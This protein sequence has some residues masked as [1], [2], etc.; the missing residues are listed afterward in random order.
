[1]KWAVYYHAVNSDEI[2][3]FNIFEHCGFREK[4]RDAVKKY[5]DKESF[6]DELKSCLVYHFWSK[7]EW[8]V[9][10]SAWCGGSAEIKIDVYDQ[11]MSNW[12][13]FVDYCWE[14]RKDMKG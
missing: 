3:T 4:F 6:A 1:M 10:V 5:K 8:E 14:H 11:V 7:C 9:V 13:V 2:K 12:D